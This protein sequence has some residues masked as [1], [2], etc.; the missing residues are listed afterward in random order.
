[1]AGTIK[2]KKEI[3]IIREGGKK[4][5]TVLDTVVA[6]V[7]PGISTLELDARAERLIFESGGEPSFKG[8]R[9]KE[10]HRP[11][12][13]TMCISINDE[14]VHAI[15]R[16]DAIL[17]EGDVVGLDIGMKYPKGNGFFTD[18][19]VTVGVGKI[20][21]K[22]EKLIHATKESLD[23]AIAVVRSGITVGDIGYAVQNYLETRGYG[24]IRDLA[25]HGVGYTVHE[26]PLIPNF[27]KPGIGPKLIEGMVIAIEPMAT[28]G[29]WKVVLAP[30]EWTFK[31]ADGSLGAHFEHTMA[32][33]KN[34]AEVLTLR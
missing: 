5:A 10:T 7:R 19:A 8:Y 11:Y 22:A 27:G 16:K 31:T 17:K 30:D 33:T 21:R 3:D 26:D 25:G 9:V 28:L 23:V 13:C 15:P 29:T 32:V 14:V 12:P 24:V 18:M 6:A 1:M 2:T 4:L 20:S 34:G